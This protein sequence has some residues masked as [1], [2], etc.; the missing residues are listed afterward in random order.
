MIRINNTDWNNLSAEDICTF[1]NQESSDENFFIEYKNDETKTSKFAKEVSAFSNTY[2]GYI[3]LG[4]EDDRKI[5]GCTQ[6]DEGRIHTSIIDSISPP[7]IF[8]VKKFVTKYGAV[9]VVRVEQGPQPPYITN[10]GQIYERISSASTPITQSYR[11]LQIYQQNRN[12]LETLQQT[13]AIE[14]NV[15]KIAPIGNLYGYIDIG[16]QIHCRDANKIKNHFFEYDYTTLSRLIESE[17]SPFSISLIGYS[18]LITFGDPSCTM[19]KTKVP[20][21]VGMSNL[22]EIMPDGSVK[23]R[24]LLIG[25][26]ENNETVNLATVLTLSQIYKQIYS[27]LFGELLCEQFIYAQ[28]YSKLTVLRQ[29][30]P[31]L[32]SMDSPNCLKNHLE[33]HIKKYGNNRIVIGDRCPKNDFFIIDKSHLQTANIEY[34]SDNIIKELFLSP[35]IYLGY[36]E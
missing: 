2:G 5:T 18:L 15:E 1:L 32:Q 4:V 24:L 23:C 7:P 22:I 16:F 17:Y 3:F 29:F 27:Q 12:N 20:S 21:P 10:S 6:W 28:H 36:I 25:D 9:Y 14:E 35:Y 8:D 33:N 30:V 31:Q 11:L 19:G 13:L 34:S 26:P